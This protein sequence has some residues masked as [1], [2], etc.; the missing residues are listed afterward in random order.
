MDD[1]SKDL[2]MPAQK[3]RITL[4]NRNSTPIV[5]ERLTIHF[6]DETPTS[7]D[8]FEMETRVQ[9]GAG[10]EAVFVEA[11]TV[12]NPVSYVELNSVRY[13]DGSSWHPS[14]GAVCNIAP[15]SLKT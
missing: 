11:T 14:E 10:Q 3:V 13:A 2:P 4:H 7:G 15:E 5:L 8:P 9:V 1:T 12:Q 6:S